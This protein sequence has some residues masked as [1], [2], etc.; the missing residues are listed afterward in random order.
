MPAS[1]SS[2]VEAAR[3]AIADRLREIRKDAGLS[4][5]TVAIS[6]GWYKSKVSRLENAVTPAS[7]EDIRAWCRVC[8]MVS[9]R[10]V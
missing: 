4:G 7:P 6:A 2:S 3:K 8:G 9:H 5:H 10:V 1:P